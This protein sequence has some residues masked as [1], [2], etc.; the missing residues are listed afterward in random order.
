MSDAERSS[1]HVAIELVGTVL[2][3]WAVGF[4]VAAR[5][6]AWLIARTVR[7]LYPRRS[8]DAPGDHRPGL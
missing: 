7:L 8:T 4:V 3:I 6:T 2:R 1:G 5:G